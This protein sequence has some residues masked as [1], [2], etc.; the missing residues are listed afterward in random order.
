MRVTRYDFTKPIKIIQYKSPKFDIIFYSSILSIL[1]ISIFYL[2]FIHDGKFE[3][4]FVLWRTLISFILVIVAY[5]FKQL[6]DELRI[7]PKKLMKKHLW[8]IE[9]LMEMTGK[10]RK[11]T[12]NIIS[13]VL[14]SCFVV[15]NRNIAK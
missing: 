11:E 5:I 15:D 3:I 1:M 9:E 13:H 4:N 2:L 14:E 6:L 10:D 12:E 7:Y 8:T